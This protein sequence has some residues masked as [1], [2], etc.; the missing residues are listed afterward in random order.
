[1]TL[2]HGRGVWRIRVENPR[3]VNRGVERVTLDGCEVPGGEVP[4]DGT[5]EHEVVVTLLGG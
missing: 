4:L 3:G 1:M 2:R 5:G